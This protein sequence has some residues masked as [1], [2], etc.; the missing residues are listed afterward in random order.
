M[1][2]KWQRD[3]KSKLDN[4]ELESAWAFTK[5]TRQFDVITYVMLLSNMLGEHCSFRQ[6]SAKGI[7]TTL[8]NVM[9]RQS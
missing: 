7:R 6:L 2:Y 8:G 3:G 9:L 4:P 5:L 1:S